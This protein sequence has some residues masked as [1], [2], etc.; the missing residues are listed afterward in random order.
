MSIAILGCATPR[1]IKEVT[2]APIITGSGKSLTR[3][4]VAKVIERAG[5][6]GGWLMSAD[7]PSAY[8]ARLL[9]RRHAAVVG[10]EY[11]TKTYSISYQESINLD[12]RDGKIH[13][14]YNRW[15]EQLHHAIRRELELL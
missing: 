1:A 13:K 15:V 6:Y 5:Q 10:I 12:A 9:V 14:A 11:G 2:D 7:G 4:E 8:T 3:T